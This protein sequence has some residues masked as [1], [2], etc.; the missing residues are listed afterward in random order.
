MSEYA[1]NLKFSPS[2]RPLSATL[3]LQGDILNITFKNI[4]NF[5]SMWESN[6]SCT[7]KIQPIVHGAT[8]G[9]KLKDPSINRT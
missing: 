3:F 5:Q 6:L 1:L 2:L 4:H 9:S 7:D 8:K